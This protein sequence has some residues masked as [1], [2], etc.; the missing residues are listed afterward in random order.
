MSI[1]TDM[2]RRSS[3]EDIRSEDFRKVYPGGE[4]D[5]PQKLAEGE[6]KDGEYTV[7]TVGDFPIIEIYIDRAM[8]VFAGAS[9][10]VI[11][12]DEEQLELS[13]KSDG[14]GSTYTFSLCRE[15]DYVEGKQD[16]KKYSIEML[17]T[18]SERIIDEILKCED[19][20]SKRLN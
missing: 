8:S 12:V 15:G 7:F 6:Y 13:R 10:I 9:K 17:K 14:A 11:D 4:I 16:G 3:G 5:R 19:D 2:Q 20:I 1:W 18:L